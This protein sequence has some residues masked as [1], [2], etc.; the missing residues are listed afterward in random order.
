MNYLTG[1][2][3]ITLA[4]AAERVLLSHEEPISSGQVQMAM[5]AGKIAG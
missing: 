3:R 5:T 2:L 1:F 4:E